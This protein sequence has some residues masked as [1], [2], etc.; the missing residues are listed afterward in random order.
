MSLIDLLPAKWVEF[1]DL[2]GDYFSGIEKII[3]EDSINPSYENIFKAFSIN[4]KEVRVVIVGQDP[5]PKNED[6]VGL[7]FSVSK[8]RK[9]LPGSLRNIKKEL[10]S[11]VGIP[12]NS[13]GDLTPWVNQGVMLLNRILTTK[14]GE[15]LS[16]K[17]IG[18]EDFTNRVISR[19]AEE[20]V[21]FILWGRNAEALANLIPESK[22]IKGVHPSPLSANRGFF[23]SKPF[24]QVN[25]KL[26]FLGQKSINW[27]I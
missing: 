6:A 1:L 17:G 10:E 15:S 25:S 18:W 24:T 13:N 22:V 3:A 2:P 21:I 5:Y 12:F 4:P 23:G 16:H 8:N 19:L 26:Q 11:D 7:A 20:N 27:Q 9:N 14:S